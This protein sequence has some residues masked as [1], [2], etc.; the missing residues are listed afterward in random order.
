MDEKEEN[1]GL[2]GEWKY[3]YLLLATGVHGTNCKLTDGQ[4]RSIHS[5]SK[6]PPVVAILS[7]ICY[8]CA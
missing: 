1:L 6:V 4:C 5:I 7:L 8:S 3:L 2:A